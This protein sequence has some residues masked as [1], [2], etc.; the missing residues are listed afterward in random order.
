MFNKVRTTH[1]IRKGKV[2]WCFETSPST[3]TSSSA[4]KFFNRKGTKHMYK[5]GAKNN[6]FDKKDLES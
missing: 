6:S 4:E 2:I 3:I 1:R 5:N